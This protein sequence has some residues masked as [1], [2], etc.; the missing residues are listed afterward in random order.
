MDDSSLARTPLVVYGI[1]LLGA[2]LAYVV[3]PAAIIRAQGPDSTL[4]RVLGKDR[5]GGSPW[6]SISPGWPAHCWERITA[7]S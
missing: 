3:V 6:S 2:A 5:K 4:K 7:G 1:T